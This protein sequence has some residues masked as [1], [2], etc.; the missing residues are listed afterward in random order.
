MTASHVGSGVKFEYCD[1]HVTSMWLVEKHVNNGT[2]SHVTGTCLV[3]QLVNNGT[4]SH[5]TGTFLVEQRVNNGTAR[6]WTRGYMDSR[7]NIVTVTWL[8]E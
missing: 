8:V 7:V 3:E 2:A 6:H 1:S 5:V 4:A